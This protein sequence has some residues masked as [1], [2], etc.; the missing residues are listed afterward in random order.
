[1]KP[2]SYD[3]SDVDELAAL[4]RS[5]WA[6]E[7]SDTPSAWTGKNP[8][9]GQCAVTALIV[10]DVFGGSLVRC[11]ARIPGTTNRSSHFA[12]ILPNGRRVDLTRQQFPTGTKFGPGEERTRQYVLQYPKTMYRYG[13]LLQ[14][15]A[16]H[17]AWE[18][19]RIANMA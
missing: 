1:M 6:K 5:C 4:L 19:F 15:L 10:Q 16:Q 17:L 3:I 14:N 7:T 12:N 13:V 9:F 8:A 18:K 2:R 11:L